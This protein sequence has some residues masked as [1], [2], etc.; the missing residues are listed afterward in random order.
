MHFAS[1]SGL[2]MTDGPRTSCCAYAH[3][4]LLMSIILK[5]AW[6]EDCA[7]RSV[8]QCHPLSLDGLHVVRGRPCVQFSRHFNLPYKPAYHVSIPL[9][10]I[11]SPTTFTLM[12]LLSGGGRGRAGAGRQQQQ[13]VLGCSTPWLGTT[14]GL[15]LHASATTANL[16]MQQ[17][18]VVVDGALGMLLWVQS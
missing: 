11:Q 7:V 14:A 2:I 1:V 18:S 8:S 3:S 9:L 16:S 10:V 17:L 15:H 6:T 12:L 5:A 13:G 4:L